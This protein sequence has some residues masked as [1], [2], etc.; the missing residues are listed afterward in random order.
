MIDNI[1]EEFSKTVLMFPRKRLDMDY[2]YQYYLGKIEKYRDVGPD[3]VKGVIRA[4]QDGISFAKHG[5]RVPVSTGVKELFDTQ[6]YVKRSQVVYEH[7]T[8]LST[9]R[10]EIDRFFFTDPE[11]FWNLLW[12]KTNL[13]LVTQEEDKRLRENKLSRSL[14]KDGSDRY[15]AVSIIVSDL[16]LDIEDV[17]MPL[18]NKKNI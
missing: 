17:K 7:K 13:H 11:K 15:E 18:K 8:P 6:G 12:E 5:G 9:Y 2:L 16:T 4:M 10:K 3:G 1:E 14:P